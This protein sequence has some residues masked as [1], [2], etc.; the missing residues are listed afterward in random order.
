MKGPQKVLTLLTPY[1]RLISRWSFV[2]K[3]LFVGLPTNSEDLGCEDFVDVRR[4]AKA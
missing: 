1:P 3:S 4:L 2:L